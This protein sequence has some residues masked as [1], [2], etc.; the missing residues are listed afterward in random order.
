MGVVFSHVKKR[1]AFLTPKRYKNPTISI[2]RNTKDGKTISIG[3]MTFDGKTHYSVYDTEE[4]L[5][6]VSYVTHSKQELEAK[7]ALA[8]E[9]ESAHARA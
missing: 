9:Q 7:L 3:L 4:L 1:M 8:E 6:A 5:A 2:S